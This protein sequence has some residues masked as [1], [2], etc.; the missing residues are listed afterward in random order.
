MTDLERIRN[1]CHIDSITGCWEW[2]G[3]TSASNDG[4][5]LSPRVYA[6]DYTRNAEGTI[7]TV[8]TGNRAAWHAS[9]LEPIPEGYRVYRSK[10]CFNGLCVNPDH[11][12][13][14]TMEQWGKNV[15][16]KGIWKNVPNRIQANR[17]IG[18]KSSHV[19]PEI[20][21]LIQ[22]SPKTGTQ[23]GIELGINQ[24]VISRARRGYIKSISVLA[25]PFAG[26]M[27]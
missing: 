17:A 24:S 12:A 5:T 2:R 10:C 13:C 18:R 22:S 1:R 8:Q 3:S 21:K 15:A 14:G 20:F 23:L 26:L 19:T 25:N 11:L 7:K 4:L 16:K 9:T 27:S 6:T